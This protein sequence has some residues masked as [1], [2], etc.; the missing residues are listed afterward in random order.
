MSTGRLTVAVDTDVCC[1]MG[2]CAA[3]EPK[4]FGQATDSGTVVLLLAEPPAE[5]RESVRLCADLCPC[6]A[7]TVT[8][9]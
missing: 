2:R 6:S 1:A 9:D 8:E 5:L 3:T 7:I 4:V